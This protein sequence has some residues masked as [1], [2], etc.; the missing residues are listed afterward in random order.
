MLFS[1]A[2]GKLS[3][4]PLGEWRDDLPG[5][6][7]YWSGLAMHPKSDRL[8]AANRAAEPGRGH[9][10]VIDT[11]S[12]E[13]VQQIPVDVFTPPSTHFHSCSLSRVDF[14]VQLGQWLRSHAR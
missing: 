4:Q 14:R 9:V 5:R 11:A 1:Y 13:A 6:E 3:E 8:Y 10:T 7:V 12:G 2:G